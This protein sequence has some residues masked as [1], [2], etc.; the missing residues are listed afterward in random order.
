MPTFILHRDRPLTEEE[1]GRLPQGAVV[2]TD[3]TDVVA[4]A[5]VDGPLL[6]LLVFTAQVARA[7]PD[8]RLVLRLSAAVSDVAAGSPQVSAVQTLPVPSDPSAAPTTPSA[9]GAGV[10]SD[11][12]LLREDPWALLDKGEIAR[13]EQ[14]FALGYE[15]DMTGRDRVREMFNSTDPATSALGC[16]LAGYTNWKSF[17]TTLRRAVDHADVRVRRDAITAIGKLAGPALVPA[18]E[19]KLKDPSPEVQAAASEALARIRSREPVLVRRR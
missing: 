12:A 14:R 5:D 11:P 13:A 7:V 9:A 3:T 2:V 6:D 15:L 1:W 8:A 18:V 19:D 16:R 10:P 4:R 17:V